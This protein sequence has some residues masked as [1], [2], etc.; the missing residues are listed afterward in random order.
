MKYARP[1]IITVHKAVE[2]IQSI[3]AT[4]PGVFTDGM[5]A[6]SSAYEADE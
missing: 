2:A 3:H 5:Q 6:T 1:Q 4:K